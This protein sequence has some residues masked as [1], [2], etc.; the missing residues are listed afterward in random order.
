MADT[1]DKMVGLYL[2][3]EDE[4]LTRIAEMMSREIGVR[5]SRS[6]AARR[7]IRRFPLPADPA[8]QTIHATTERTAA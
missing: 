1:K 8:S 4:R 5:I 3:D 6:E 7:I 2:G